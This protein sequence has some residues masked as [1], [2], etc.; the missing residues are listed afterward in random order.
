MK[1]LKLLLFSISISFLFT[2]CSALPAL[3]GAVFEPAPEKGWATKAVL[4][5]L[6]NYPNKILLTK[7]EKNRASQAICNFKHLK[8][9]KT[10]G[11]NHKEQALKFCNLTDDNQ[12]Y[13]LKEIIRKTGLV[14]TIYLEVIDNKPIKYIKIER[15]SSKEL[16]RSVPIIERLH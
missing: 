8:K 15:E 2:G 16:G 5:E 7:D 6:M 3:L 4:I 9:Y 10:A 13:F 12:L 11:G 1:S 14:Q